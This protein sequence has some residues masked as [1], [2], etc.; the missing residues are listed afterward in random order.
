MHSISKLIE[1]GREKVVETAAVPWLL[2]DSPAFSFVRV[3][4]GRMTETD[5][6]MHTHGS[7]AGDW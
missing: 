3:T 1:Q 4:G 2:A 5:M 6:H 7:R